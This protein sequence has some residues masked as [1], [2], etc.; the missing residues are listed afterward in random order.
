MRLKDYFDEL[1][2][3]VMKRRYEDYLNEVRIINPKEK[4]KDSDGRTIRP[5]DMPDISARR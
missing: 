1:L 3:N 5:G 4:T 2:E